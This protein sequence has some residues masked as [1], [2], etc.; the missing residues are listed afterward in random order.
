MSGRTSY[1]TLK[2]EI[3]AIT[4]LHYVFGS[5]SIFESPQLKYE[6]TWELL[7]YWNKCAY[8]GCRLVLTECRF[9]NLSICFSLSYLVS[10]GIVQIL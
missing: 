1:I 7:F 8:S 3:N 10:V 5:D 4:V 6:K 9:V 2:C